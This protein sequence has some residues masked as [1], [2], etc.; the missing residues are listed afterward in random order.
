MD[1]L[2][3]WFDVWI[4]G[5]EL[6]TNL[7]SSRLH[8]HESSSPGRGDPDHGNYSQ[9]MAAITEL[10]Q[11]Q[12]QVQLLH[13]FRDANHS[14]D[15]LASHAYSFPIHLVWVDNSPPDCLQIL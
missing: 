11:R 2:F 4:Q 6:L 5:V 15:R 9:V 8:F 12:W 3:G 1:I 14:V 7:V 13:V 10:L